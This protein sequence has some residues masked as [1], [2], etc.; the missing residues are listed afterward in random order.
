MLTTTTL[1]LAGLSV[2]PLARAVLARRDARRAAAI[3]RA[4][5]VGRQIGTRHAQA[6]RALRRELVA[7][8]TTLETRESRALEARREGLERL[9]LG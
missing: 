9:L 4:F 3:R 1:I 2:S 7:C 6:K 8:N 5:E